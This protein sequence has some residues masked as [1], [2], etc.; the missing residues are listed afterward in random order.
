MVMGLSSIGWSCGGI[1]GATAVIGP[2]SFA[3]CAGR[4]DPRRRGAS[5]SGQPA[6]GSAGE[7]VK[8]SVDGARDTARRHR[9][10]GP[11]S[12]GGGRPLPAM[13]GADEVKANGAE[14][15]LGW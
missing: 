10:A 7:P 1:G 5:P 4:R 9:L 6:R 2:T 3:G 15:I 8:A 11:S 14:K 12:G 13:V